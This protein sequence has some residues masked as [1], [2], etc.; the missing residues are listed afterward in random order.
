MP[1]VAIGT[2]SGNLPKNPTT[3]AGPLPGANGAPASGPVGLSESNAVQ[4]VTFTPFSSMQISGGANLSPSMLAFFQQEF[5]QQ[6]AAALSNQ[7][8]GSTNPTV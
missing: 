1:L 8:N 5:Q 6:S 2:L 4:G 7:S 3:A